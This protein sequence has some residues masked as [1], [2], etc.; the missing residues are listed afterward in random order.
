MKRSTLSAVTVGCVWVCTLPVAGFLGFTLAGS[1][2]GSH[3]RTGAITKDS[4]KSAVETHFD[5]GH[6]ND[7]GEALIVFKDG[8]AVGQCWNWYSNDSFASFCEKVERKAY[9]EIKRPAA[10][11]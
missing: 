6:P 7:Q 5:F 4:P 3:E 10:D 2:A 9:P 1:P 11:S 8:P